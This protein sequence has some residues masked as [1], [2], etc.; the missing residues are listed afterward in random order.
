MSDPNDATELLYFE[1]KI[2]SH[3]AKSFFLSRSNEAFKE[4]GGLRLF[5]KALFRTS[6]TIVSWLTDDLNNGLFFSMQ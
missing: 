1:Q 2:D 3:F 6:F 4:T 5:A